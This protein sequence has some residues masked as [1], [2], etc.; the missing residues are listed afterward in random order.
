MTVA[1]ATLDVDG[2]PV[3]GSIRWWRSVP[4]GASHR[5]RERLLV[6]MAPQGTI[7]RGPAFFDPVLKARWGAARLAQ[8]TKAPVIPVGLWGT[9]KVWPRSA[10][11][12]NLDFT[13]PPT[14]TVTVGGPIELKYKS[15]EKD[16]KRIM[17]AIVAVLPPEARE[18][19]DPT[20]EELAATYPPGYR[21]DPE[22]E[23]DRRPGTD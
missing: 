6:A 22:S 14:V 4:S 16:T 21:G 19:H 2:S 3:E 5:R 23:T 9:E 10:K 13:D 18:P 8:A 17:K 15:L 1:A 7:P 20:P 11:L 12:P